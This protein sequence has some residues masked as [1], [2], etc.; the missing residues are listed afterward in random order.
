MRETFI[1]RGLSLSGRRE[2]RKVRFVVIVVAE[3]EGRRVTAASRRKL[4]VAMTAWE[5]GSKGERA[6]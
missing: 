3:R 2:D 1:W 6:L 4:L 5:G